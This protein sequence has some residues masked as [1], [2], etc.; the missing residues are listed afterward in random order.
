MIDKITALYAR[1]SRDEKQ[2][3]IESV[4]IANQRHLLQEYADNNGYTNCKFY[5]DDGYTGTNFDRPDFQRMLEDAENGLIST[6]IVKDMSRFGRNYILVGKYVEF[7]LPEYGVRVIGIDDNY[8]S[9]RNDNDLFAFENI[10]NE[11]YTA[12]ISKKVTMV[13]RAKAENGGRLKTHPIYGYKT[14]KGTIDDWEIDEEAAEV[15]RLIFDM[16]VN[17]NMSTLKISRYL[18]SQKIET[19]HV[20]FGYS[21]QNEAEPYKWSVRTIRRMLSY[22]EYCGDTVNGKTKTINYKTKERCIIPKKEWKIFKDT[23]P[24]II[25]RELF[26]KAQKKLQNPTQTFSPRKY[27]Y[28]TLF[29]KKCICS[30]CGKRMKMN[31]RT[32]SKEVYFQCYDRY[33]Y[34]NCKSHNIRESYLRKMFS[35]QLKKLHNELISDEKQILKKIG[36]L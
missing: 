33:V 30:E 24:A 19:S 2:D 32:D 5:V 4:S 12:D 1:F 11:M 28:D 34:N 18:R 21:C 36:I 14:V 26:E 31:F 16:Y 3:G 25:S 15:V 10:L 7:I 20:H 35:I 29:H 9:S 8:N 17:K 27:F 22:Q 13:K 6:I 23:H